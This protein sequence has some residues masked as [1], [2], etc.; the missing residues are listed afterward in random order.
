MPKGST[1]KME[2]IDG[3]GDPTMP[4]MFYWSQDLTL[5]FWWDYN[6]SPQNRIA[7]GSTTIMEYMDMMVAPTML[8]MFSCQ[9]T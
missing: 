9:R 3:M 2:Y 1:T 6:P 5:K 4:N 8:N 7:K